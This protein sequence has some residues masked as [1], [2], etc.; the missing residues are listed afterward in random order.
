MA[1]Q[2]LKDEWFRLTGN[3]CSDDPDVLYILPLLIEHIIR[4]RALKANLKSKM[5]SNQLL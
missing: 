1:E 5:A 3:R 2:T 4:F